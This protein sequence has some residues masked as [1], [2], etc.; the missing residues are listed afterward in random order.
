MPRF[1][2]PLPSVPITPIKRFRFLSGIKSRDI[3]KAL[4][5]APSWW[6]VR[7]NGI[8]PLSKDDARKL[9]RILK[10]PLSDLFEGQEGD[11]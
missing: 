3:A 11:R 6:S 1:F 2:S 4:G 7:E 5:H 10:I 8:V 9:S